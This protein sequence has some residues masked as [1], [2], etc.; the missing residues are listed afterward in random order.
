MLE[1]VEHSLQLKDGR[2]LA[3]HTFPKAEDDSDS[4]SDANTADADNNDND[5]DNTITKE[6]G[7]HPVLY[8][9]GFPSCGLEGGACCAHSVARAG[10][11]LF[12]LD[13][14]G[15]GKT[16]SPYKKYVQDGDNKNGKATDND[17]DNKNLDTLIENIWELVEDRGWE[18]FSV[19]GVSGGGPHTLA[20][21][22][23]Y[24]ERRQ[25][26]SCTARLR[27][28][29][30]V[31]AVCM[32]AGS[33]G[34]NNEIVQLASL[35]ETILTTK[36]RWSRFK[37]GAL[38]ASMGVMYNY[39]LP[40]MP[41][42]LMMALNNN[43]IKDGPAADREFLSDENNIR[44]FLSSIRSL[45]AQGGN[46]GI[47]DDAMI[48]CKAGYSHEKVL[49]KQYGHH[50]NDNDNDSND[51]D[52]S[53]SND[54][55]PAVGIFQGGLDVNVPP[56]HARFVHESI[57]QK[58]SEFFGYDDLGHD[59]TIHGKSEEYAAFATARKKK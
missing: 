9:H 39:L 29:C 48:A 56:S 32:S 41:L 21:L 38:A 15:M 22:A 12:A 52:N 6:D 58:R 26:P 42:S 45:A 18:E 40:A 1:S 37:L 35:V 16:S 33:D 2:I 53:N 44:I 28:V 24:L 50:E 49:R 8:L 46:P 23:S 57:F 17:S 47:Y 13:R 55:L 27:N 7:R 10:G 20:L 51:N 59:S 34:A 4:D 14:P 19:I 5:D 25:L 31:G 43:A 3:Y 30:M 36:S 54:D 11:R